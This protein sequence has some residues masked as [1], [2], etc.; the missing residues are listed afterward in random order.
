MLNSLVIHSRNNKRALNLKI[1]VAININ[2]FNAVTAEYVIAN[3]INRVFRIQ[4]L[5]QANA[6]LSIILFG[7]EALKHAELHRSAI[8]F[9]ELVDFRSAPVVFDIVG[10]ENEL[11]DIAVQNGSVS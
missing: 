2:P 11:H 8:A 9:K 1:T 7:D 4:K 3:R 5:L 6:H 10:H